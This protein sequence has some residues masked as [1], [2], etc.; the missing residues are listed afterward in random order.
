MNWI[1]VA[2][3]MVRDNNKCILCRR[4]AVQ[5]AKKYRV[6]VSSAQMSVDSRLISATAFEMDLG[7]TSCVSCGQCIAVCPTGA[8]Y[9]K[10]NTEEVFA[11]IADP[12]EIC[13]SSVLLRQSVQDSGEAFGMPIGTDVEGKL[14]AALRRLGFDKVFDTDILC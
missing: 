1:P 2:A 3:H 4:C 7:D 6:W 12:D 8:L 5:F 11:A 14:A 10:D 9:E 13:G